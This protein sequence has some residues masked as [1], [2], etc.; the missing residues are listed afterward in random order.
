[1][2]FPRFDMF[3]LWPRSL[4]SRFHNFQLHFPISSRFFS[5]LVLEPDHSYDKPL[6]SS[7]IIENH[8]RSSNSARLGYLEQ[9]ETV[10][11][12]SRISKELSFQRSVGS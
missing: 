8:T 4:E 3:S 7:C 10:L 9:G 11:C 1:M 5:I 6:V 2:T 12:L